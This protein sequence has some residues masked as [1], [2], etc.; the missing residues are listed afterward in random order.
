MISVAMATFNGEK[1]LERQLE[2]VLLNL[3]PDDEVVVSDDGSTD[4]TLHIIKA[5][6]DKRMK[7]I[8]GPGQG[9]VK[10]FENAIKNCRGD[11]I[12]LCDQDDYWYPNKVQKVCH[13]F[14]ETDCDLVEHNAI[15]VHEDGEIMYSSF[16]EYRRIRKG[17]LNNIIRNTYHGCL[18]AFRKELVNRIVPFPATGC[19]HDQWIGVLAD[20][21]G[22]VYFFDEILMEYRRHGQNVSSFNHLPLRKQIQDRAILTINLAKRIAFE[23]R[24]E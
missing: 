7:V 19:L 16:F 12:F 18:M 20:Y 1:Y 23:K 13:I 10:N 22:N 9:V 6:N 21:Y 11:Y 24:N 17:V 5:L 4:S 8:R 3:S 14:A 2:S 15:I